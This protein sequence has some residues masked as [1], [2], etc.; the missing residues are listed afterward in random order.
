VVVKVAKLEIKEGE[1]GKI[2]GQ[3]RGFFPLMGDVGCLFSEE[4]MADHYVLCWFD[5]AEDDFR[6][7]WR[8]LSDVS[9]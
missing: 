5:D 2:G 1:D 8:R 7:F 9:F 6:K 3:I 4:G